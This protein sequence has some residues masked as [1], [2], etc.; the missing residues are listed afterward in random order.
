MFDF[1]E[2]TV[3]EELERKSGGLESLQVKKI[4][5]QLLIALRLS[6]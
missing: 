3:L 4:M 1:V 6:M 2:H 5:Y